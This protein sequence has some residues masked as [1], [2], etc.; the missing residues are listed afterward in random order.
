MTEPFEC[1]HDIVIAAP[2]QAVFDYVSNPNS[3]PEW[4]AA[5]HAMDAPD[6][7]LAKGETFQEKWAT[8]TAEVTL[9][10]VVTTCDPPRVWVAET[11]TTF[12]G[13]IVVE[14]QFV[15]AEGG[16]RYTRIVRNPARPKLPT[17]EMI[18]RIEEE[19][20]IALRNIKKYVEARVKAG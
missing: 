18:A 17:P 11:N 4:I 5:S 1:R 2:A 3:W 6:R 13:P 7:P 16:T 8:R 19:A 9:D 12:I 14:Y 20:G 15:A 10:W